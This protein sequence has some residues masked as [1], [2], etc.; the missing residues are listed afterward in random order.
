VFDQKLCAL[1][2]SWPNFISTA[3]KIAYAYVQ[4]YKRLR[5]DIYAES[6]TIAGLAQRIGVDGQALKKSIGSYNQAARGAAGDLFGRSAFG[7][8]LEEP[9]FYALG[10]VKSWLV[11]TEG[12]ARVNTRMEALDARGQVIPGLYAAGSNGM[13]GIVIWGHGLHLAWAFTSGRLAGRNAAGAIV[14]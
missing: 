8:P 5:P 9:P 3:P 7:A 10:P 12:G 13:G 1:F 4:D 6:E 14:V 2:S 11:T